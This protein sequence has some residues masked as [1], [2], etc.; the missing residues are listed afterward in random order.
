[1]NISDAG[2]DLIRSHEGL[3]LVAYPDVAGIPTIGYGHT[4]G[5]E[6]GQRCTEEEANAW[7]RE[8]V[9]SAESCVN[10]SVTVP[11]TQGEF[12]ACVSFVYNIGCG[13]FRRSTMLRLINDSNYD[14][15]ALEFAKWNHAGGVEVAGL[16]ARR[17]AERRRFEQLA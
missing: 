12:D 14:G 16:T 1:M 9:K 7:L 2:L 5:V 13:N 4:R 15:A 6:L 11:L 3:R 10:N 17:E 8:D